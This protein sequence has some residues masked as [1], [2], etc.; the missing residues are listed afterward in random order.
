MLIAGNI[1]LPDCAVLA[2]PTLW[3]LLVN[4]YSTIHLIKE[5]IYMKRMS[6]KTTTEENSFTCSGVEASRCVANSVSGAKLMFHNMCF[7]LLHIERSCK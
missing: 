3:D 5:D 1:M 7:L 2:M 6:I 4:G